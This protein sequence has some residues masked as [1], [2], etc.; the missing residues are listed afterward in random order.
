M[1]FILV[2]FIILYIQKINYQIKYQMNQFIV[3]YLF[4]LYRSLIFIRM[5]NFI[6]EYFINIINIIM[7]YI[8]S[9]NLF[10]IYIINIFVLKFG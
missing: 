8:I 6:I 4:F 7:F 5:F 1:L 2:S 10:Q 3:N 9:L